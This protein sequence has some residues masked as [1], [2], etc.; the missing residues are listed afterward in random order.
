MK[1]VHSHG[2]VLTQYLGPCFFIERKPRW[3][4]VQEWKFPAPA[5][6]MATEAIALRA[7]KNDVQHR[8]IENAH[9]LG[10]RRGGGS[11]GQGFF[12]FPLS[13]E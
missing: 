11:D 7:Q 12:F 1:R 9:L 6:L 8:G 13:E 5:K 4:F 2:K 3:A 10:K